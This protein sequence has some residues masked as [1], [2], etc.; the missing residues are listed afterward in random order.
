VLVEAC[1][2]PALL[3]HIKR[4]DL[5][6]L[7]EEDARARLKAFLAPAAK[8]ARGVFPGGVTASSS[9]PSSNPASSFPG[10]PSP[11]SN[12]APEPCKIVGLAADATVPISDLGLACAVSNIPFRAPTHFIGRKDKLLAIGK[13]LKRYDDRVVIVAL[14]GMR[15]VGKTAL[16]IAYA[17]HHRSHNSVCRATW[18]IRAQTE[19]DMRE[20]LVALGLRLNWISTYIKETPGSMQ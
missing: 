15:G 3:A 13:A 6:S 12:V 20:D 1:E 17:E 4:C 8:P 16:A 18:L 7:A 5:Y 14:H 10:R 19:L 9:P 11:P 2:V